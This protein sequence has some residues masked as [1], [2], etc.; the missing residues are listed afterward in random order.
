MKFKKVLYL[1][2]I[3]LTLIPIIIL[4][5]I[6]LS[7]GINNVN[8]LAV[9]S[10]EGIAQSSGKNLENY[11]EAQQREAKLMSKMKRIAECLAAYE[12]G[13][14]TDVIMASCQEALSDWVSTDVN[15]STAFLLDQNGKVIACRDGQHQGSDFSQYSV[16]TNRGEGSGIRYS[17][18]EDSFLNPGQDVI[19]ISYPIEHN[20]YSGI[21]GLETTLAFYNNLVDKIIFGETGASFIVNENGVALCHSDPDKRGQ[22]LY[23]PSISTIVTRYQS[24]ELPQS[25]SISYNY[26]N[27]SRL[28]G[29]YVIEDVGWAFFFMESYSEINKPIIFLITVYIIFSVLV[30]LLDVL[31]CLALIRLYTKPVDKLLEVF[32]KAADENDYI[33]CEVTGNGEFAEL[34][35]GY[36]VMIEQLTLKDQELKAN[37][38][39]LEHEKELSNY[40]AFHDFIT[41]VYNR[42]AFEQK[43]DEL[44]AEEH[45][46]AVFYLGLDGFKNVNTL[47]GHD[48]GDLCL[49]ETARRIQSINHFGM[50]TA[51]PG[52]DEFY[53][54]KPGDKA[55]VGMLAEELL[56]VFREPFVFTQISIDLSVSIGIALFPEDGE[57]TDAVMKCADIA[58]Y[59]AKTNG[60]NQY[61]FY[62]EEMSEDLRYNN[63]VLEVL[64]YAVD[65]GEAFLCYQPEIGVHKDEI[66][67]FE[68]LMRIKSERLGYLSPA[69]FIPLAEKSGKIIALGKWALTAAVRFAKKMISKKIEFEYVAV[70]ISTIQ[71]EQSDFV[72]MVKEVLRKEDLDPR[73][74]MLEITES[75]L[76]SES[77]H[78]IKKLSELREYG[79]KIA[80]DDF[81]TGY[82]SMQYLA[83]LPLDI[84]KIDKFFIDE[85]VFDDKKRE[86]IK[87][88]INMV[89]QLDLR[90]VAEGVETREQSEL[91][92]KMG[93][94]I[95]QG[96]YYYTPMTG[97]KI[98]DLCGADKRRE[99]LSKS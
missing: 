65:T 33:A 8:Q 35:R 80:L 27:D 70:N 85:I 9:Q 92:K 3:P 23:H 10:L 52:G 30:S 90:V 49:K 56:Q 16:Y 74:M 13:E 11:I 99:N 88:I 48:I 93:C 43:L 62:R 61:C 94:D 66:V 15:Y 14:M 28:L 71:L 7:V 91:L 39:M 51:R 87:S 64:D 54:I 96:Y 83:E 57:Q 32:L 63:E 95:I 42:R 44:L 47:F 25:G 26:D 31:V 60:K 55:E 58:M 38:M 1:S 75:V 67:A 34:A 72:L 59:E 84:L 46:G 98:I 89:H 4:G 77:G 6:S 82:S 50:I 20:G 22:S 5:A 37:Y 21:I 79:V 68:A 18:V 76:M 19:Y 41:E 78:N 81:G 24:G 45:A 97:N 2:L 36:N 53:I 73:R 17:D 12:E 69:E 86:I 29:Y 40:M